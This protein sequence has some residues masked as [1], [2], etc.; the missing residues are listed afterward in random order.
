MK[1][2]ASPLGPVFCGF[3]LK[4]GCP[5]RYINLGDCVCVWRQF[6]ALRPGNGGHWGVIVD[7]VIAIGIANCCNI[8]YWFPSRPDGRAATKTARLQRLKA[9]INVQQFKTITVVKQW[10][11]AGWREKKRTTSCSPMEYYCPFGARAVLDVMMK[12]TPLCIHRLTVILTYRARLYIT[13]HF[14]DRACSIFIFE[15]LYTATA[16]Y[17]PSVGWWAWC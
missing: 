11:V 12:N 15:L 10:S 9:N 5:L 7:A 1:Q 13:K 16:P 2:R 4:Y 6:S 14:Y 17:R 3:L 8:P